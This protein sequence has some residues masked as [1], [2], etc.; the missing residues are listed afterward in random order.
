MSN[1]VF[2]R[3]VMA[4]FDKKYPKGSSTQANDGGGKPSA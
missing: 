1:E 3:A 4:A 2:K